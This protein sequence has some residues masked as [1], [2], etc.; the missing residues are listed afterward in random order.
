MNLV[1]VVFPG[2]HV[3]RQLFLIVKIIK[4][5]NMYVVM[6]CAGDCTACFAVISRSQSDHLR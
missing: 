3:P 4:A 5:E 2:A 1:I 6:L